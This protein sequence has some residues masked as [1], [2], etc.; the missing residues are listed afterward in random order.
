M[1][2]QKRR[3]D[4]V[5]IFGI[6]II[7][8]IVA[9]Y[10]PG[11]I[12]IFGYKIKSV[13]LFIDIKPDS[14]LIYG[15]NVSTEVPE[16]KKNEIEVSENENVKFAAS[17]STELFKK[18]FDRIDSKKDESKYSTKPNDVILNNVLTRDI[19]ITGNTSQLSYFYNS[20]RTTA[21]QKIR[22]AHYGDSEVEGDIITADIR[23]NLQNKFGGKGVGML[24][25]TSQDIAF[26][27]TT[28][29][30][31][32]S[33]WKQTNVLSGYL[34]TGNPAK[35]PIGMT[36]F[37]ATPEGVSWVRYETT[38]R[39]QNIKSFNVV[40]VFYTNAKSS[41]IKY[42]FNNGAE[43]SVTLQ[44]GSGVKELTLS[45][46]SGAQSIK[47]TTSMA[48]QADFY[49]V[50]LEDGNG[51]YID[52]FPWRG[53]TGISFRDLDVG[54]LKDFDRLCNYKLIII[55]FGGNQVSSGESNYDWFESQ[56]VKIINNLKSTFPQS[57]FLLISVGDKSKKV[58]T[59]LMTDP[60]VLR[61][62]E[63]QKRIANTTGI[64]FW[65]LFE[66]MGGQNSMVDW[67]NANPPLAVK[68]YTHINLQGA[69]KIADM[70][71]KSLLAG[72]R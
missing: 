44:P 39:F 58:G 32:S 50:S 63:S 26:R 48:G 52:N 17:V 5:L 16:L 62:I 18:L 60:L 59:R 72:Y 11:D 51:I 47:I 54:V 10:I 37:M 4:P 68:D 66:A 13:D 35:L 3:N 34:G 43:Q 22:V 40:R 15:S 9:S 27:T 45:Y 71:T 12:E 53:N 46:P 41:S 64:A 42:S 21:T 24:S 29:H 25:I 8:L 49:G 70:L 23:D 1:E 30:T 20:L 67:V 31:F 28:K 2:S 6:A 65:N 7:I 69:K 61:L 55:N 38:G 56:M 33:N 57:S 36:G 14:L 19:P